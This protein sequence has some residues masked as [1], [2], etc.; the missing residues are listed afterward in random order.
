MNKHVKGLLFVEYIRMM[1]RMKGVDWTPYL[2][3][4]D[5]RFFQEMIIPSM[6]YPLESYQRCGAAVFEQVAKKNLDASRL[7]GRAS[8]DSLHQV[9]KN[10]LIEEGNPLRSVEKFSKIYRRF[11]DFQGFALTVLD[12]HH[13]EIKV[14]PE[15]GELAV[16][17]YSHQMLGFFE[18]LLELA[19]A[20]EGRALFVRKR[21]EG[22]PETVI[23]VRWGTDPGRNPTTH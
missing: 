6:W 17:A 7:W 16:A 19:R 5:Q 21:W 2:E 10:L 8:L 23:D 20:P 1:K 3:P 13:L 22:D 14:S 11:F 4:R 18:R 9:Y 12:G 15:F